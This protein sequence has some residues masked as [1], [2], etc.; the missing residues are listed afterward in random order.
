MGLSAR[1]LLRTKEAPYEEL[2]LDDP[3]WSDDQILD[4]IVEHPILLP[5]RLIVVPPRGTLDVPALGKR[6]REIPSPA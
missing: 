4:F 3:K 6:V 2:K 5:R 1:E